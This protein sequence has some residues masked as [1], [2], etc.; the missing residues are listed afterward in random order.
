[1]EV[2]IYSYTP[3]LNK[4]QK[5]QILVQSFDMY[6]IPRNGS[7]IFCSDTPKNIRWL[8]NFFFIGGPQLEQVSV[9]GIL[10]NSL[11]SYCA[12]V[13]LMT[14][15]SKSFFFLILFWHGRHFVMGGICPR[16]FIVGGHLSQ[17]AYCRGASVWVAIVRGLFVGA[18]DRLPYVDI[19]T[20]IVDCRQEACFL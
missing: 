3:E 18:F 2:N 13:S 19:Y 4:S 1:M 12:I 6:C 20:F 17:G 16:G 15:T 11:F 10:H 8:D 9:N 5:L 14:G 7:K